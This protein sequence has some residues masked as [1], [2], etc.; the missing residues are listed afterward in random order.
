MDAQAVQH[1]RRETLGGYYHSHGGEERIS[2]SSLAG[3]RDC[4]VMMLSQTPRTVRQIVANFL[5]GTSGSQDEGITQ[6]IVK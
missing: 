3:R 5:D 6:L 4:N 2:R 1:R